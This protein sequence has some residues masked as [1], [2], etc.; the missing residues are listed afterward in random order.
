MS[1]YF[2]K[3]LCKTR[4]WQV[5]Y[6]WKKYL[7]ASIKLSLNNPILSIWKCFL[8]F[9]KFKSPLKKP[10]PPPKSSKPL[11]KQNHNHIFKSE[12]KK[13]NSFALE[14]FGLWCPWNTHWHCLLRFHYFCFTKV[15]PMPGSSIA[16]KLVRASEVRKA[17]AS[18]TPP[19]TS[20][21]VLTPRTLVI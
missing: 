11:P 8:S 6:H 12:V 3:I 16:K 21:P 13:F 5:L 19:T 7:R 18:S 10:N 17:K 15:L 9:N 1:L 2:C 4:E 20:I 14:F